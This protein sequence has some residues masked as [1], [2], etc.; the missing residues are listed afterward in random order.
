MKISTK[1][2]YALRLMIDLARQPAGKCSSLKDIAGRQEI[3]VKYLEQIVKQLTG[4]GY[5]KSV[6]GSQGG[7]CLTR[8]PEAYTAGE[9]LRTV[10]GSLVPVACLKDQP[11]QCQRHETCLTIDFWEG[12]KKVVDAYVDGV[13]LADLLQEESGR[14]EDENGPVSVR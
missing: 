6:R 4:A 5:L 13:T 12:L 9:I 14:E 1:G 3:S 8:K 11:N 10:E 2:R 7:Y